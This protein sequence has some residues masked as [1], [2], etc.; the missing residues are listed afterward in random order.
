M[1][2]FD[3]V[4]SLLKGY[5][6][7]WSLEIDENKTP[8]LDVKPAFRDVLSLDPSNEISDTSLS[9]PFE[10]WDEE[11]WQM[12]LPLIQTFLELKR[13]KM[14]AGFGSGSSWEPNI[15][16]QEADDVVQSFI[17][18]MRYL[19]REAGTEGPSGIEFYPTVVP[20]A[21]AILDKWREA[22]S[23]HAKLYGGE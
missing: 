22:S 1:K 19:S 10:E 5:E 15:D 18:H 13:D 4:W 17:D 7:H 16:V 23:K 9:Y 6:A 20:E 3:F 14:Q 11:D 12:Q 2:P 8:V 21:K